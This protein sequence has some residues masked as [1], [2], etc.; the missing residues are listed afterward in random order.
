MVRMANSGSATVTLPADTQILI[1]REF[2]APKH[3]VWRAYTEP[4]LIERWWAGRRGKM[5]SAEVELRVGGR[6]RYVMVTPEGFE[7]A[8][9]G[10]Y[11]EVVSGERIVT[12][13][14]YEGA[15]SAGEPV[16]NTVTF[17]ESGGRTTLTILCDC[18]DRATRDSI[19]ESSMEGGMQEGFDLLEE[20]ARSLG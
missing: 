13:E 20:V 18:P 19:I 5:T 8:F 14:V 11:R 2:A 16:V 17:E 7:V 1:A 12:T 15:P 9:N 3:L 6:W 4:A 10:E